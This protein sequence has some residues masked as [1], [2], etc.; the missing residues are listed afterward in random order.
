MA[1]V[2]DLKDFDPIDSLFKSYGKKIKIPANI[3]LISSPVY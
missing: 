1:E 3:F 2:L